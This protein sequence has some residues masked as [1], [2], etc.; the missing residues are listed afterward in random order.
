MKKY[1]AI[2][3]AIACLLAGPAH[4]QSS[5]TLYGTIDAGLDYISNQKSP[6]GAGPAY[7][8][9]SGNVS[10]SR[11]GLRGNE[12]LGDGL[13]AVFTLEN[14]FNG[15]NGKFGNGGDEFGRQAWVGLS[16]RR[17]GT[18]TLGRQYDFL[19]DFVAPLSATGSGFGG[20][21]ADHPYDNDNLANDTRMNDAV[22][23]SSAKYGGFSFG[24]AYGF[25]NQGGAAGNNNAYSVGA[26]YVNGP[27]DLAVAYLQ[28]NQPGGVN[29]PQNTGGSLSSSDGDAML[30]GGR[31]RTF[32]AGA[33]Y[34]FDH[35]TVGFVYTRTILNDPR[36]LSQGGA[37][38]AVNGRLLT[39]SNYEL[40]ARYFLQPAF[41]LGGSY[42]LTQGRFDDAGR[43]IAPTWS[44]FMLQA[45]YAL[46]HRT[47]LYLEGVYQRVAGADGVAVLGNAGIFNLAASGN[48]R[49][50]VV[51]AGIRHKF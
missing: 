43:S 22:K 41:S 10:T 14:G 5:V 36:E 40:N 13:G 20:N 8:V 38:G 4:A 49:Q 25:S 6:A 2:P 33:H 18:V 17:W 11:W 16:S 30:V 50:A 12:D 9:Q 19:V 27:V 15:A 51:A 42:T 23:F 21:I 7:G 39:F 29:A 35:A 46:S 45:D 31:W 47:D 1:L 26:Q 24:G 3:A 28:S 44:Q 37:Y 34:A 32:G 48:D